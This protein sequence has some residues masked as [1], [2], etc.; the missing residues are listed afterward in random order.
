MPAKL[1]DSVSGDENSDGFRA[2]LTTLLVRE[3]QLG[4]DLPKIT[5]NVI[6]AAKSAG[7]AVM[8]ERL[9]NLL[10]FL[11]DSTPI[12]GQP[13]DMGYPDES[14]DA[15]GNEVYKEAKRNLASA[16][17]HS[18]SINIEEME[19]LA[20]SLASRRLVD[21]GAKIRLGQSTYYSPFGFL[22]RVTASGYSVV[23]SLQV[24]G[25]S[26]QCFVALWFNENTDALYDSAIEPAVKAAGYK[27]LR[28][29]RQL[30]FLSKIDDQIIAEI[31]RSRFV[32]ADFTHD[33]R[34]A[35]GSVYYEAG[36]ALGL[37]IP[38]I[39]TCREDLIDD[40][41]FDTS[42]FLHL[43]WSADTPE[44]LKEPLKSRILA[45]IGVGPHAPSGN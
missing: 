4:N 41:H 26:D 20:D 25:T 2:R 6:A 14:Q 36:F 29:D 23:E 13:V 19:Y 9:T 34:G 16:L 35:R 28:I 3:R 38:V 1:V 43:P 8:D 39:F 15:R 30:N 12:A 7:P 45:N 44:V 22:C 33:E 5:M 32:I 40:L 24:E 37:D 11:I 27:P 31:R 10:R 42:H 21:K 17:A 18:E